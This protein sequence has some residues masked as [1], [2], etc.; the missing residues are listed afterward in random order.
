MTKRPEAIRLGDLGGQP[1]QRRKASGAIV[2]SL[3]QSIA[4]G[5]LDKGQRLP[6]E[7]ELAAHFEVSQPTVREA[8]RALE[9]MGLVEVRHGSGAYVTGDAHHFIA[10]SLH[11]LLQMNRVGIL[12][13]VEMRLALADYDAA[14]IVEHATDEDLDVIEEQ[15]R[16]L[17]EAAKSEDF[18]HIID[19]AVA[20]QVSISAATHNPLLLAIE[21][22]L[23]EMLVKIQIDAFSKRNLAFW[24]KWSLQ[25]S[26]DRRAVMDSLR[27]RDE[28][29]AVEALRAYLGSQR[30]R[31]STD[32]MLAKARLSDP[33][34]LKVIAP[35]NS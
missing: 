31:F 13:V 3:R 30:D 29:A 15:G 27:A 19:A 2:E 11:T 18:E 26:N 7:S 24:R 34:V 16:R 8:L 21:S 6:P 5:S 14:R 33:E 20:F 12:D 9:A 25:F 28:K 35:I 23:A 32:P 4:G 17:D 22:V 1:R 10:M